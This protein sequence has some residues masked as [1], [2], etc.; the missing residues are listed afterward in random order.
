MERPPSWE[1]AALLVFAASFLLLFLLVAGLMAG[2]G[3]G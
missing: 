3:V 2:S 1:L